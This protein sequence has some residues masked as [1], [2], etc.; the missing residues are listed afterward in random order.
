MNSRGDERTLA[1][2]SGGTGGNVQTAKRCKVQG[3][4]YT[5]NKARKPESFTVQA[6][7]PL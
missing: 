3:T 4:R 7:K 5:G 2:S 1:R 6:L